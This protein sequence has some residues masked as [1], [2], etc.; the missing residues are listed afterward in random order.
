MHSLLIQAASGPE[1]EL[2]QITRAHHRWYA[3]RHGM[4][5]LCVEEANPAA[6]KRSGWAKIPLILMAMQMG[7]RRI[8][9]LDPDAVIFDARFDLAQL[10]DTGIGMVRH[11]GPDHWSTGM[12]AVATSQ[13]TFDFLQAVHAMPDNDHPWM[14]QVAVNTLLAR[15]EFSSV[16]LPLTPA[17]HSIPGGAMAANPVVLSAFGLPQPT[18]WE[19]LNRWLK[20]APFTEQ[21]RDAP[22]SPEVHVRE[23][24][25]AFL[26]RRGLLGEAAEIGVQRG[27]F[28]RSLLDR[29]RGSMLH[30]VDPWRH[31]S[32]GYVDI[33]NVSNAQHEAYMREAQANLEPHRDRYRMHRQLSLEAVGTFA[34]ASLDF[35]YIDANHEFQAVLDDI[36]AWFPKVKPGGVL[37]GHDYLDGMLP[38]GDFGVKRAVRAFEC[39][40]GLLAQGTYDPAWPSWYLVKQ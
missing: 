8:I 7:F 27:L 28:S 36:H 5:Y 21:T 18:R 11:P 22:I 35:V 25:G 40:T 30:L 34:D 1:R 19:Y 37:A 20:D 13:S 23:D 15:N 39:E 6:P 16:V 26:N 3:W 4:E 10:V 14:E 38:A 9:W 33:G 12:M 32:D 24:F 17:Y 31:F 2:L 29:W